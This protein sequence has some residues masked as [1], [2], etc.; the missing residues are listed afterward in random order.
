MFSERKGLT[1][2]RDI[3][4]RDSVDDA[5]RNGLWNA[6]KLNVWDFLEYHRP[7]SSWFPES[8]LYNLFQHYW[9]NLYKQPLDTL[10]Q[11]FGEAH[12]RVRD[13]YFKCEWYQ[14]YDFIEFTV[15][16]CPEDMSGNLKEFC[17]RILEKEMSGYRFIGKQLSDI[18]SEEE[19]QSIEN[20]LSSSDQYSGVNQHISTSLT[21]LSDRQSP[22][23]RNS[24]KESIS[25]VESLCKIIC[26]D[27]KTTLGAA[28]NKLERGNKI[29]P[30]LKNAFSNLYGY[31][32][33]A[34]GIRHAILDKSNVTYC[35]AK[36]MLVSCSS[37]V[38]YVLCNQGR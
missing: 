37:F 14:V 17:N 25:S 22:D 3:I 2:V 33:D 27:E 16:N 35:D 9:H 24:V 38:N 13:M 11:D 12:D 5:L 30:A 28:L 20:A 10:P 7:N 19:I 1:P 18:T 36:F 26:G 15:R 21:L 34:E 4:Q 23:Y 31:T 6:V 29:H 32:S 8:N